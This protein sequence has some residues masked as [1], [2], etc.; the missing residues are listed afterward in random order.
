VVVNI[1]PEGK[2]EEEKIA[3]KQLH[4]KPEKRDV[5][6]DINPEGKYEDMYVNNVVDE[7][8]MVKE[9]GVSNTRLGTFKKTART[10]NT[11]HMAEIM[12]ALE[13]GDE[14][15]KVRNILGQLLGLGM[16]EVELHRVL[17][18]KQ[19]ADFLIEDISRNQVEKKAPD[20]TIRLAP[21]GD[22]KTVQ[23]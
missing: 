4:E 23:R 10:I 15:H 9:V 22:L 2:Y 20:G 17:G 11:A 7:N 3:E 1:N 21:I 5:M 12:T 8:N 16:E 13:A 19:V 6:A 18:G 14:G